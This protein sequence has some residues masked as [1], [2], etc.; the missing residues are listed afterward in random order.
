M[1][2]SKSGIADYSAA[3]VSELEKL[4]DLTIFDHPDMPYDP[5]QFDIDVY[6]VGN[7]P[8]H[9]FVYEAAL[10]RPGV[11]VMHEANLHHLIADYTIRR[12]DWDA[13]MAEVVL[14][15]DARD[16]EF[17][18]RVRALEVGPDYE[19]VRMTRRILNCARGVIV[20]S[21][22]MVDEMRD[23]GFAGPIAR[24]PHGSWIPDADRLHWRTQL[25]LGPSIPLIGAF[26]FIKPYK[27]I[28]ES[29][30]AMRRLVRIAPEARMI[31]VG[32]PHPE[33][34]V[35]DLIRSLDLEDYVRVLGFTP[36][37]HFTGYMSACDIILNLRYPTVGESSGSMLRALGLGKPVLVSDVGAFREFPDS[38]CLKV[39]VG[40]GEEDLIFEYL[41]LLVSRPDLA[42]TL[43]KRAK[44]W[45]AHE[46]DWPRV[47]G[48]H[49]KFIEA[50]HCGS[51]IS[52]YD[53]PALS[54]PS[55]RE[56]SLAAAAE[57][58]IREARPVHNIP[59]R[60]RD[61]ER[62][63][64]DEEAGVYI[65]R[66]QARLL[67]TLEVTPSGT[68][69]D[70]VLEMGIY[71]QITPSLK[72]KL[73]YGYVRGC[74][75][76]EANRVEVKKVLSDDGQEFECMVD[77]FDAEKDRFPYN[78]ESFS[79]V[80]C[81]ELIEH[82]FDDPMFMMSE[83]NRILKPGG[84]VVLTTPN[85][86]SMRALSAI[87]NGYHPGFFPS[88][89]KPTG[90]HTDHPRHNREYTPDDVHHLLEGSGFAVARL[91]TGEFRDDPHPDWAYIR[92][93]LSEYKL[94]EINRG[95][96]IYAVGRKIGPVTDRWPS[97]LY[98]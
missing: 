76:G 34:P 83:I 18:E 73:G 93:I 24:I 90:E 3:L 66:H 45:V 2:P 42:R 36:I 20:H 15:G 55:L 14:N 77:Y 98:Y 47:A 86:A 97:W 64:E 75:Y 23:G 62:W 37:E 5:A 94:P 43:G 85:V 26:G 48:M 1:P 17:S 53:R 51:T 56:A 31:L 91:E 13:Y 60:P 68:A 80:L 30:R 59:F 54:L 70:A 40:A 71:F 41:N 35:Q 39:T 63:A 69:D 72:S 28:P 25:G 9:T 29:L 22:F 6:H 67:K 84:H 74:Y 78:D 50:V 33:F 92:H 65:D 44:A 27:R 4:V 49:A 57:A 8:F 89:I 12:G 11:V 81:C 79:T 38:V 96:G 46:C 10:R 32:E 82:L 21:Q 88:Y 61:I 52:E 7:N 19:G 58:S 87:L 95:D 16:V